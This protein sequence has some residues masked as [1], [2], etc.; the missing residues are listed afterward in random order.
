MVNYQNGKIY[1]LLL[2][3][4][5]FYIGCTVNM[6]KVRKSKHK[7]DCEKSDKG[8]QLYKHVRE[9]KFEW[10]DIHIA[11]YEEY[12]CETKSEL[13]L[14]ESQIIRLFSKD[15]FCL[16]MKKFTNTAAVKSFW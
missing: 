15:E 11:L 1:K 12:S 10:K 7:Y 6:L 4:G 8:M 14:R 3:D 5:Y 2:P 13:L 9:N 16:N